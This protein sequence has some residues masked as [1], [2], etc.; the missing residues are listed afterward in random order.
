[1]FSFLGLEGRGRTVS[2]AEAA[3]EGADI[4]GERGLLSCLGTSRQQEG[5]SLQ[6]ITTSTKISKELFTWPIAE[7]AKKRLQA[8]SSLRG[9]DSYVPVP[10]AVLRQ[11]LKA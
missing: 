4:Q 6:T 3:Y 9:M 8:C 2:L 7:I 10:S 11:L 5:N 1:M